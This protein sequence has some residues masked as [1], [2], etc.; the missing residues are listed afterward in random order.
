MRPASAR[1]R[2]MDGMPKD[3]TLSRPTYVSLFLPD[4]GGPLS[5]VAPQTG[6]Q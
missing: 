4:S 5:R 1:V 2:R 3:Y 6:T